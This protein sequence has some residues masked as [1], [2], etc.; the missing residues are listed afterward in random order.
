MIDELKSTA[1]EQKMVLALNKADLAASRG[2]AHR[3]CRGDFHGVLGVWLSA[4]TGDGV[5][6]LRSELVALATSSVS[7]DEHDVLITNRRHQD[8][9]VRAAECLDR[10]HGSFEQGATNEFIA[11]DLRDGANALSEITGEVTSEEILNA[12]FDRFCIGK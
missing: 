10:A 2:D 9:L 12:I 1:P 6:E 3:E 8:S 5:H 4:L 11:L 7:H